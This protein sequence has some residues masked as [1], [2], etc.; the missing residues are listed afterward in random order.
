MFDAH[1]EAADLCFPR[2]GLEANREVV[3]DVNQSFPMLPFTFHTFGS[4]IRL[5][6]ALIQTGGQM[7]LKDVERTTRLQAT[8]VK[9]MLLKSSL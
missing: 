5:E 2:L 6:E 8:Y 9:L 1:V 4:S 3:A 7:E